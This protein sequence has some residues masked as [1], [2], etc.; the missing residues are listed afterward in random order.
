MLAAHSEWFRKEHCTD[1]LAPLLGIHNLQQDHSSMAQ[2]PPET[3]PIL[4]SLPAEQ[5][6]DRGQLLLSQHQLPPLFKLR[7]ACNTI[8]LQDPPAILHLSL[9]HIFHN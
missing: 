8:A 4:D 2:P 3:A 5:A 6:A 9:R 7:K 1:P